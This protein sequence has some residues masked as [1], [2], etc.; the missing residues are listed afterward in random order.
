MIS[1]HHAVPRN[2]VLL[3]L[4]R[5]DAVDIGRYPATFDQL[6]ADLLAR[7]RTSDL[8]PSESARRVAAR[9]I[10]RNGRYRPTGRGKPASEYL[11]RAAAEEDYRFP[12]INAPVD[13]CNYLS[14]KH[15]LPISLWD[16]D[17][18]ETDAFIF[19]LGRPG[20]Q[21]VFN[22]GGQTIDVEDLLV[23][24]RVREDDVRT[25]EAI[26]NPVK[27]SL[28]TKTTP[29]TTRVAAC[30]Y[31]PA[32]VVSHKELERVC[33]EFAELLGHCGEAAETAF[34]ILSPGESAPV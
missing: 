23:G 1:V 8:T 22:A 14:L 12:R 15:V 27:D 21:Y 6:L 19:R 13:V 20:E 34:R 4:V 28:L 29:Q 25:A 11:L 16:L 18:A 2:D 32:S 5:A 26:V 3:G 30:V 10:L 7:R 31:T 33:S 17:L 24:C 9:D